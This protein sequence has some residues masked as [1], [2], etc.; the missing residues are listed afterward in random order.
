MGTQKNRLNETILLSTQ[1]IYFKTD[2]SENINN[3]TLK[4]FCLSKPVFLSQ[5]I[6]LS[7]SQTV[8]DRSNKQ[9]VFIGPDE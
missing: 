1:N 3:F 5:A 4:K 9:K 7:A 2:R 8:P 6:L